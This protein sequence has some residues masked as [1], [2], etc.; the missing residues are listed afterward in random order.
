[1]DEGIKTD[2]LSINDVTSGMLYYCL[3]LL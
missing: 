3:C 2:E 1:M